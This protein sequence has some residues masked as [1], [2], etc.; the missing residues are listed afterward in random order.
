MK[1]FK[2]LKKEEGYDKINQ[3]LTAMRLELK[4]ILT[5]QSGVTTVPRY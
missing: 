2:V 1:I 3:T 4:P 5:D